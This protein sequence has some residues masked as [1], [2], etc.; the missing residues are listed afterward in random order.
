MGVATVIA[1]D[2]LAS[3]GVVHVIDT[4]LAAAPAAEPATK[5]VELPSIAA[6]AIATPSL[7]TLVTAV[8]A[9]GLVDTLSGEGTFTVFAPNNGA[10]AKVPAEALGG[11]L[12][13]KEALTAVLLR[14]VLPVSV[15]AGD[16][17]AGI[18]VLKTVGGEEVTVTNADGA[19]TIESNGV[20]ATVIA[21]DVLA[22]NGVVHVIDT[23]LA[24]APAP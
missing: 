4:V 22:S 18:T 6:A 12:E 17:P 23:V 2:V 11:L 20:I 7:S 24:A 1:T 21:T 9:A 16:I 10:F 8:K 13:D 3:N 19:V 15:K 14:H 5:E